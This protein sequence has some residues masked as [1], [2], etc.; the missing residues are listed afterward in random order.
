MSRPPKSERAPLAGRPKFANSS[1]ARA[2]K[3]YRISAETQAALFTIL[4][5]FLFVA[6]IAFLAV[7]R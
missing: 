7:R 4:P 3:E 5:V 6:I 1:L 2:I